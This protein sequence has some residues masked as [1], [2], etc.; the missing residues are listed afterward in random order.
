MVLL[1]GTTDLIDGNLDHAKASRPARCEPTAQICTLKGERP[2]NSRLTHSGCHVSMRRIRGHCFFVYQSFGLQLPPRNRLR[3]NR[4]PSDLRQRRLGHVTQALAHETFNREV[5]KPI[6]HLCVSPPM[7]FEQ[8][9]IGDQLSELRLQG[10]G[11][12]QLPGALTSATKP[13]IKLNSKAT[14]HHENSSLG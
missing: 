1:S 7:V 13:A 4:K 12:C 9:R 5:P 3:C 11:G 14:N 10:L 6:R 8:Q 2:F